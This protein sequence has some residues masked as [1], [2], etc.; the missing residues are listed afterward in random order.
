MV[1]NIVFDL[2]SVHA[3][4]YEEGFEAGKEAGYEEG[5]VANLDKVPYDDRED[6]DKEELLN[7]PEY[8][9]VSG[10]PNTAL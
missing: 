9:V 5:L 8:P 10:E 3:D 7:V 1:E 6:V 2:K 4:G